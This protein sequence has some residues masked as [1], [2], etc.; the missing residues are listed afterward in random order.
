MAKQDILLNLSAVVVA[1]TDDTPRVLVIERDGILNLPHG[2]FTPATDRTL[3]QGMRRW[4]HELTALPLGYVEQ[5]YTFGNR[6]RDAAE[7]TGA[8]RLVTVSYLALTREPERMQHASASWHNIY[9]HLPWEDWRKGEPTVLKNAIRPAL[10]DWVMEGGKDGIGS[11]ADRVRRAFGDGSSFDL[12]RVQERYHLLYEA[13]LLYEAIR[14]RKLCPKEREH[15]LPISNRK[16]PLK[17]LEQQALRAGHAMA[18]DD[19]RM[20]ASTLERMRGK[21]KYRPVVFELLPEQ[22]TLLHLQNTVES[23][24]GC[25]LHKQNFRRLVTS[26]GLVEETGAMEILARGRPAALHRFRREVLAERPAS[27]VGLP[28]AK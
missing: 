10:Q 24:A 2:P 15:E 14:D 23:L 17:N 25:R 13:G 21:L 26:G 7:I 28:Q 19:R 11:R 5:L 18:R 22:F 27:G 8:P 4:I 1:V 12:E 9:D 3:E 6:F 16:L 20:L